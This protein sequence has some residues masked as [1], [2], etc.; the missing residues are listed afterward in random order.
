MACHPRRPAHLL[1]TACLVGMAGLTAAACAEKGSVCPTGPVPSG[2]AIAVGARANSA[3]PV[4]PTELDPEV[5][6]IINA[7]EERIPNQGVTLVRVDGAPSIGCVMTFDASANNPAARK[8]NSDQFLAAVRSRMAE[9]AAAAAEANPLEALST[10]SHA[11]GPG[12]TVVLI[13]SGLQTAA[14]LDFRKPGL[15]EADIDSVVTAMAKTKDL[16]DLRHQKVILAGIGYTAPPQ[17][18]LDESQRAH[19]IELWQRLAT[20]AGASPV[21]VVTKPATTPSATGLPKVSLAPVPPPGELNLGCNTQS[22]LPDDGPVGFQPDRTDF[23]DAAAARAALADFATW[24]ARNP[25]AEGVVTGSTAHYGTDAG[26][27]GLSQAR[28]DRVR[29]LLIDLGA[30]PNQVTAVGMGW[31]PFPTKTAPPDPIS[32]PRNRRVVIQLICK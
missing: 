18:P 8:R 11:A 24:L 32:D 31:G 4:W 13:D 12:G 29:S 21:V 7:T 23:A 17:A 20:A 14:P 5:T 16:P 1:V 3:K 19:L 30:R 2:L 25:T 10:A 28:A 26:K 9:L 22:T 27:G 15:L 6:A